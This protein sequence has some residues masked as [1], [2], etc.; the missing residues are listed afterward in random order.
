MEIPNL[1][2]KDIN[3]IFTRIGLA[4]AQGNEYYERQ[5]KCTQLY[6]YLT[7]IMAVLR[8]LS[9]KRTLYLLDSAC[10]RSY[11]S[12]FLN[13]VLREMGRSNLHFI[14]VDSNA[15]LIDKCRLTASNLEFYNM[16]FID[17]KIIDC[18]IQHDIDIA[19]NLHACDTATDQA[20][21]KGIVTNARYILSVS[22]CQHFT[23]RQMKQHPLTGITRHAR[24][25]ER[26]VDMVSDSLR[27]LL[28]ETFGYK[29]DVFE[30]TSPK[31][32][33]KNIILR[34]EWVN[35][36]DEKRS[37]ALDKYMELADMFNVRPAL[38]S[39]LLEHGLNNAHHIYSDSFV[40][41]LQHYR[42]IV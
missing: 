22:C 18:N 11:L 37:K 21:L 29:V 41:L 23:K 25:K 6:D 42:G 31:S 19:Y 2:M 38:A 10:G 4:D 24:Y 8:K 36:T 39:Y 33:P 30:F 20:I 13:Y 35:S 28:L 16:E 27:A 15:E 3:K 9:S 14:G 7:V 32:T 40:M 1:N 26:M 5:K 17:G 12:F 34:A